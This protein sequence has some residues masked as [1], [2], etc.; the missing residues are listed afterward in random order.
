MIVISSR[1][2]ARTEEQSAADARRQ[3]EVERDRLRLSL[4]I[5]NAGV[6]IL[7]L[8]ELMSAIAASV[9]RVMPHEY[10]GLSL[11]DADNDLLRKALVRALTNDKSF[12]RGKDYYQ[13]SAVSETIRQRM[14]LRGECAGS[15]DAP[16]EVSVTLTARGVAET[17]CTCPYEYGGICKH[18]VALLLTY[19]HQ[20][21]AFRVVAPTE[22][23]LKHR[24]KDDLIA[25]IKAMLKHDSKLL[26]LVELATTAQ[27]AGAGKAINTA[28]IRKQARRALD[29]D[30][31]D[32]ISA[33]QIEK[34]LCAHDNLAKLLVKSSDWVN[35][36]R[37]YHA[38]LDETS[39]GYDDIIQQVDED[40]YIAVVVE[41]FAEGLGSALEK[42]CR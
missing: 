26:S 37:I 21:Q 13:D 14:E 15:E 27:D 17:S 34:E 30:Y 42:R 31:D 11:Y 36:G 9:R 4:E 12:E 19:F 16:Y 3:L 24:S 41:T 2:Q 22:E 32:R 28:A 33:R 25:I 23:M 18:T 7:D 5:N 8:R 6:T 38:L 35:A 20:P 10:I 1:M 39:S 40:G 29:Y